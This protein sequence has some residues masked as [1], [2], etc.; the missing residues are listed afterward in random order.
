MA[1]SHRNIVARGGPLRSSGQTAP[2]QVSVFMG[3]S[4]AAEILYD[5]D[6]GG[7][8]LAEA[9][10]Y[11]AGPDPLHFDLDSSGSLTVANL[12]FGVKRDAVIPL[13]RIRGHRGS[14]NFLTSALAGGSGTAP[15][16]RLDIEGD[17]SNT[18]VLALGNMFWNIGSTPASVGEVWR[19]TS[20]P[21]AQAAL[22]S[23]NQNGCAYWVRHAPQRDQQGGQHGRK[24]CSHSRGT[25]GLACGAHRS[26]QCPPAQRD[27]RED[28]PRLRRNRQRQDDRGDPALERR[29]SPQGGEKTKTKTLR[30]PQN[31]SYEVSHPRVHANSRFGAFA[32]LEETVEKLT[33]VTREIF[34]PDIGGAPKEHP[35]KRL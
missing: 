1:G 25:Q 26:A 32:I 8:L 15:V 3:M 22:F 16:L 13:A 24:R 18:K 23:S 20:S 5:V 19:D 9:V 29:R 28:V 35:L 7:V 33:H 27:G 34:E 17:G 30:N 12:V 21:P 2:G 10:W 6:D 4:S 31:F 14:F 11:E